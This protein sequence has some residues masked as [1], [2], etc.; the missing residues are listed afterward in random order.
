MSTQLDCIVLLQ[1]VIINEILGDLCQ[2][3]VLSI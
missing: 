1:V 2:K 3:K